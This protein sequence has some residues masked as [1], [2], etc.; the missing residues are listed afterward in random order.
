MNNLSSPLALV[1]NNNYIT[2]AWSGFLPFSSELGFDS[3]GLI[4]FPLSPP[5]YLND[6]LELILNGDIGF[7]PQTYV[8]PT[9]HDLPNPN[10]TRGQHDIELYISM[11]CFT[12]LFEELLYKNLNFPKLL[13]GLLFSQSSNVSVDFFY[14]FDPKNVTFVPVNDSRQLEVKTSPLNLTVIFQQNISDVIS[15][16]PVINISSLSISLLPGQIGV[17]ASISITNITLTVLNKTLVP[18][19]YSNQ[20]SALQS[21]TTQILQMINSKIPSPLPIPPISSDFLTE[22]WNA[23]SNPSFSATPGYVKFQAD[24][25]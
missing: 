16:S 5:V 2:G 22:L 10:V 24:L 1:L 19:Q 13:S 20:V 9:P 15:V 18:L 11:A 21:E 8:C 7:F 23:L 25:K 14:P 17:N 3:P 6:T 12:C 4:Y